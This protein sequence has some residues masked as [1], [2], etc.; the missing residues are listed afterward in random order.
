MFFFWS[1]CFLLLVFFVFF[2]KYSLYYKLIWLVFFSGVCILIIYFFFIVFNRY[3]LFDINFSFI[4][5]K[6][7]N[8][9]GIFLNFLREI[10]FFVNCYFEL[11]G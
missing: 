4:L 1:I 2:F 6:V 5:K 8:K 9:Y 10:G 3:V 11:I 7:G